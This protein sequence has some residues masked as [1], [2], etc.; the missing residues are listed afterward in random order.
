MMRSPVGRVAQRVG[1]QYTAAGT[2]ER[3][4]ALV[5]PPDAR[6]A[7]ATMSG[8]WQ[9]LKAGATSAA[10]APSPALG[11]GPSLWSLAPVVLALALTGTPRTAHTMPGDV[12]DAGETPPATPQPSKRGR[13]RVRAQ[14]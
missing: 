12:A 2:A 1:Q 10:L 4:A 7:P 3:V 14:M 9:H 13:G 8:A 11:G 6:R 5:S